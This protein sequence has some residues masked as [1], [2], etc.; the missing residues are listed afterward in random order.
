MGQKAVGNGATNPVH[1]RVA[2]IVLVGGTGSRL[3]PATRVVN[4][5]LLPVYDKPAIAFSMDVMK[6]C[7]VN[8]LVLVCNAADEEI[9]RSIPAWLGYADIDIRTVVQEE[10]NGIAGAIACAAN[11]WNPKGTSASSS[12][13]GHTL[14]AQLDLGGRHP[15]EDRRHRMQR[16][17]RGHRAPRPE[18]LRG[19]REHCERKRRPGQGKG[20]CAAQQPGLHRPLLLRQLHVEAARVH[21]ALTPRRTGDHVTPRVVH[22]RRRPHRGGRA[23]GGRM[24]RRGHA[25]PPRRRRG[26]PPASARLIPARTERPSSGR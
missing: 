17:G 1:G 24:V 26:R 4:K 3:F 10:P 14:R 21:R 6:E 13:S 5:H 19:R 23:R 16:R 22:R 25:R 2:G 12:R 11:T 9:Y 18:G 7:G 20:Q 8:T 15:Q